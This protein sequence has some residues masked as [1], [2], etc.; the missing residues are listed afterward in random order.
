M[1]IATRHEL[2]CAYCDVDF[3]CQLPSLHIMQFVLI[4]LHSINYYTFH[5]DW[6]YVLLLIIV[7]N[8]LALEC[9]LN[10]VS[11]SLYRRVN[12]CTTE[13]YITFH[14]RRNFNE[15]NM[16][17]IACLCFYSGSSKLNIV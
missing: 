9:W 2:W 14:F 5:F 11:Y 13:V 6:K 17:Y 3:I 15:W 16:N 4:D 10:E 1:C 7:E 12:M 8:I